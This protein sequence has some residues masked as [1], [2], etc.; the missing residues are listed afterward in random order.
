MDP[1]HALELLVQA[2]VRIEQEIKQLVPGLDDEEL[3]HIDQHLADEGS[4]LFENERD[5]GLAARLRDELA[6][7]ERAEKRLEEGTYGRSIESGDA[8]PDE[9]LEIVPWAERTVDEQA[10]FGGGHNSPRDLRGKSSPR[11]ILTAEFP[12][13]WRGT[14]DPRVGANRGRSAA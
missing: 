2:R 4:E 7:I 14:G 8:I 9:R 1:D 5:A 13:S 10:R 3:S 11:R 6:A 12:P